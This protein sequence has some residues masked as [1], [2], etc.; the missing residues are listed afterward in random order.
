[1]PFLD[2]AKLSQYFRWSM[3]AF[4]LKRTFVN[5]RLARNMLDWTYS[6]YSVKLSV[7]IAATSSK[8]RG[9]RPVHSASAHVAQEDARR[10]TRRKRSVPV[11][12]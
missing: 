2:L 6:G 4:F 11:R 8:A 7:K 10:G 12:V 3:V 9:P 1:V 5:E